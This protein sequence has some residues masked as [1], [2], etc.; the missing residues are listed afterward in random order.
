MRD[1]Q[2]PANLWQYLGERSG[3]PFVPFTAQAEVFQIV[4]IPWPGMIPW[5]EHPK[6]R[7]LPALPELGPEYPVERRKSGIYV[8]YPQIF[9]EN[10][11]RRFGKTTLGEKLLWQGLFAPEDRFGPPVVRMTADTEEH[12]RKIWDRLT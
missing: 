10:M 11:G 2:A 8:P 5:Q 6:Y 12:A 4:R 3:Q 1:F 9:A 7:G